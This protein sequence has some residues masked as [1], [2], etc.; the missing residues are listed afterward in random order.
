VPLGVLRL[1]T[2]GCTGCAVLRL[3]AQDDVAEA[4]EFR[5]KL[6]AMVATA[7]DAK[8]KDAVARTRILAYAALLELE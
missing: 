1:P 5:Q 8:K 7:E 6:E 4:V 3:M 2:L